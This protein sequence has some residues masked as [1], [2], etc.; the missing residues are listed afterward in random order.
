MTPNITSTSSLKK[1]ADKLKMDVVS[2]DFKTFKVQTRTERRNL[3]RILPFVR[4]LASWLYPTLKVLS[5]YKLLSQ[6]LIEPFLKSLSQ[7]HIFHPPIRLVSQN[8]L[9]QISI[10]LIKDNRKLPSHT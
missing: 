6:N 2:S 4:T 3:L 5:T 1:I 10:L 8:L 9:N 7:A